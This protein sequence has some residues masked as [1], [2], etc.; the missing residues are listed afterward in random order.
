MI[1]Q[2]N[3]PII[4]TARV[5]EGSGLTA[6]TVSGDVE[7]RGHMASVQAR[8]TSGDVTVDSA[9]Q[10]H[11]QTMSGDIDVEKLTATADLNSM[12]GDLSVRSGTG[13]RVRASTMSGDIR[14][15]AGVE[16]DGQSMSGRVRGG[17][18]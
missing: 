13:A 9:D 1:G 4:V 6:R 5:P 12:S 14:V 15:G 3:S 11:A 18:R 7:T 8:S 10:V 17:A 16:L 2:A